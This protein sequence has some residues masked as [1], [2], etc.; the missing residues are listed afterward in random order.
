[1]C[2]LGPSPTAL[3]LNRTNPT[4]QA[5]Q[6]HPSG[7]APLRALSD[8]LRASLAEWFSVGLLQLRRISWEGSSAELLEKVGWVGA[9]GRLNT[10]GRRNGAE[11]GRARVGGWVGGQ[12]CFM[13]RLEQHLNWLTCVAAGGPASKA[14]LFCLQALPQVAAGEAVHAVTSWRDL[15]GRLDA[16]DRR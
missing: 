9:C 16:H 6:E 5:L 3:L 13:E 8:A 4:K 7:A 15:K 2:D 1:M 12:S 10:G 14:T 11:A